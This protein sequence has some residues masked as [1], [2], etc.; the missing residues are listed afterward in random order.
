MPSSRT[1]SFSTTRRLA[2]LRYDGRHKVGLDRAV[3]LVI[4]DSLAE[5]GDEQPARLI[6]Y[7]AERTADRQYL[8]VELLLIARK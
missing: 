4:D 3:R 8:H 2:R 6:A 1:S 7:S 5:A